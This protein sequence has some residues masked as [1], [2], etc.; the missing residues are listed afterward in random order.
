[1]K[2]FRKSTKGVCAVMQSAAKHLARII[3]RPWRCEQDTALCMTVRGVSKQLH[4]LKDGLFTYL[5]QYFLYYAPTK[6][7]HARIEYDQ[8]G[9]AGHQ[10]FLRGYSPVFEIAGP[11]HHAGTRANGGEAQWGK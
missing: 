6:K 11:V 2:L 4:Y 3:E 5:V 8:G 1:M 9:R 7:A 10:P